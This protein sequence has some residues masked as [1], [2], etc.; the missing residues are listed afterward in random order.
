M[1]PESVSL[2]FHAIFILALVLL[3]LLIWSCGTCSVDDEEDE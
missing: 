3:G 1:S 2:L